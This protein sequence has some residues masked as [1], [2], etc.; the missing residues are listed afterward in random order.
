MRLLYR[1]IGLYIYISNPYV[2][3]THY[4]RSIGAETG[5]ETAD[6]EQVVSQLLGLKVAAG[7][8]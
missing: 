8:H 5:R 1:D 6:G 4:K 3:T 7:G 2:H